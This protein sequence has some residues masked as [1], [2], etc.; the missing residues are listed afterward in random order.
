MYAPCLF[1]E[2]NFSFSQVQNAHQVRKNHFKNYVI[3]IGED[4][5]KLKVMRQLVKS[6][7]KKKI[8]KI[9]KKTHLWLEQENRE[10]HHTHDTRRKKIYD[11]IGRENGVS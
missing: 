4:T 6:V 5:S 3:V 7:K 11:L 8:K 9:K 2:H 10:T 1:A